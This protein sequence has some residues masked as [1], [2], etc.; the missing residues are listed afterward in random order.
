M[1]RKKIIIIIACILAAVILVVGAIFLL[2][3]KRQLTVTVASVTA[4][5]GDEIIVPVKLT[6]NKGIMGAYIKLEF[7]DNVFE[8]LGY[9]DGN[10]LPSG[11]VNISENTVNYVSVADNNIDKD[12]VLLSLKLKVKSNATGSSQIKAVLD[13]D[14][15]VNFDEESLTAKIENGTV[16]IDTK[17]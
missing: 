2:F 11:L 6:G 5:P 13:E 9:E 16:T 4:K 1:N 3:G 7:D 15:L 10:L 17:K 8:C 14:S 12:G